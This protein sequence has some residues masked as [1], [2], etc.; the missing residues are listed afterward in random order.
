MCGINGA[1]AKNHDSNVVP[2]VRPRSQISEDRRI[3]TA[4]I[5]CFVVGSKSH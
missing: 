2:T 5:F 1:A 3:V 4:N